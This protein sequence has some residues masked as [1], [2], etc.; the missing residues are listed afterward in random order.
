MSRLDSFIRRLEAQRACLDRAV[1]LI[2]D[3]PGPVLELGLGNGRT[4]DHLR[5]R[6]PGRDIFVFDHQI[7]AHPDCIPAKRYQLIGDFRDTLPIALAAIGRPAALIHADLGTG[8]PAASMALARAIMPMLIGLLAPDGIIAG[9]QPMPDQRLDPLP[10]PSEIA[11]GRYYLYR[12]V[13]G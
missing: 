8:E 9:D 3:L 6:L 1:E 7:A 2:A 4:Y 11:A 10:L 12:A 5:Q 13:G